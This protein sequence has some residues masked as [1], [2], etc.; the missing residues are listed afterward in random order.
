MTRTLDYGNAIQSSP[1]IEQASAEQTFAPGGNVAQPFNPPL[2]IPTAHAQRL[3]IHG[4]TSGGVG[5]VAL[6]LVIQSRA[7]R[8]SRTVPLPFTMAGEAQGFVWGP[9]I[10]TTTPNFAIGDVAE[11]RVINNTGGAVAIRAAIFAK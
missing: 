8:L 4:Q 2:W 7:G 1:T 5:L 9:T 10:S 3:D 11:L 6:A